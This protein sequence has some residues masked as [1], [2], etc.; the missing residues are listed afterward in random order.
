MPSD[1]DT[2]SETHTLA[3]DF[4]DNTASETE[5]FASDSDDCSDGDV[6]PDSQLSLG[7]P[8][9]S[10]PAPR[11]PTPLLSRT[12]ARTI[13]RREMSREASEAPATPARPRKRR[14]TGA[15]PQ[16]AEPSSAE[17]ASQPSSQRRSPTNWSDSESAQMMLW[18]L[19]C[20]NDSDQDAEAGEDEQEQPSQPQPS[21]PAA[22]RLTSSQ[23]RLRDSDPDR[24]HARAANTV[25][26]EPVVVVPRQAQTGKEKQTEAAKLADGMIEA[27]AIVA[28]P[29][30]VGAD[31]VAAATEDIE[32]RYKGILSVEEVFR[33][34]DYLCNYPVK[35]TVYLK[36]QTP[37][38][39]R[40]MVDDFKRVR[41]G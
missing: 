24:H 2:A 34:S 37:E 12:L 31:D 15:H 7:T 19:D 29:K 25:Q 23:R 18:F 6:P 3:D 33:C 14:R 32:C 1:D 16:E 11:G 35:A 41:V 9:P 8:V 36:A 20:D 28:S 4:L 27:A 38:L 13:A 30:A 40:M 21:T 5:S 26:P 39:K 17:P 10:T 22:P